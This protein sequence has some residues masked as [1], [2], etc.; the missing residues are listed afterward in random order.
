[1]GKVSLI[2]RRIAAGTVDTVRRAQ[3]RRPRMID[4][5][6]HHDV[7]RA[8][9]RR[10]WS[11]VARPFWIFVAKR[12]LANAIDNPNWLTAKS[13]QCQLLTA[14][15]RAPRHLC[16]VLHFHFRL[17]MGVYF[18]MVHGRSLSVSD[19]YWI[20][21]SEAADFTGSVQSNF[22]WIVRPLLAS[23]KIW[24]SSHE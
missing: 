21:E 22:G 9:E 15:L 18:L 8:A 24:W 14:E 2:R 20:A 11:R 12:D 3:W 23:V 6:W 19:R 1:M 13:S 4:S 5:W 16:S 10:R 17:L 7:S